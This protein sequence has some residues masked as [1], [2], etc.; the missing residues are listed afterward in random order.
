MATLDANIIR[1][2]IQYPIVP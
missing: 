2:P 1:L